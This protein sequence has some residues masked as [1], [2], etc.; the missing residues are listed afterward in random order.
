MAAIKALTALLKDLATEWRTYSV[1][2]MAAGVVAVTAGAAEVW[3]RGVGLLTLGG[4]C[5]ALSI[6]TGWE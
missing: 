4:L 3:G 2:F 5:I 6:L 1:L